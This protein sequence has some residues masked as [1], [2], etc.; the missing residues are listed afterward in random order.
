MQQ[1]KS[2]DCVRPWL[3]RRDSSGASARLVKELADEDSPFHKNHLRLTANKSEKLLSMVE[4]FHKR[5]RYYN[6]NG[7]ITED[8]VESKIKLATD[9]TGE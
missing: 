8:R 5:I 1:N 3:L 4:G 9:L 6:D 2:V 7:D